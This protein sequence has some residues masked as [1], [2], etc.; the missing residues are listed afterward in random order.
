ENNFD[1]DITAL[2]YEWVE[3]Q[4][5]FRNGRQC[6]ALS[7]VHP[8]EKRPPNN[9]TRSGTDRC[10]MPAV[11]RRA[12]DG[13]HF[14]FFSFSLSSS[15]FSFSSFFPKWVVIPTNVEGMLIVISRAN[16]WIQH[17]VL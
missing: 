16:K 4:V 3:L 2:L 12:I 6:S 17:A 10:P 9:A 14:P 8:V 1:V 13:G 11:T 5:F 7:I 15:F